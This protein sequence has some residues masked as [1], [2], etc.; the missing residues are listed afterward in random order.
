[1]NE[2]S[3]QEVK[4]LHDRIR[5]ELNKVIV[6]Q[7]SIVQL[8]LVSLFSR[9]HCLLIGVPGLAKTLLVKTLGEILA[10]SFK[11]MPGSAWSMRLRLYQSTA[12]PRTKTAR[13]GR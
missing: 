9:G 5:A 4:N 13:R 7:D 11:R 8:L 3:P 1:M 2:I 12:K 6:G 10:L